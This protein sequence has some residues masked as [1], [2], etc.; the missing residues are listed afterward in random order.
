MCHMQH[1]V[2]LRDGAGEPLTSSP[3]CSNQE[4]RRVRETGN[5]EKGEKDKEER[6]E[7]TQVPRVQSED[8]PLRKK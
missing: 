4:G 7:I 5:G 8:H 1:A 6:K 2:R 3:C